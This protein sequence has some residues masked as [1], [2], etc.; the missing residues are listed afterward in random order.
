MTATNNILCHYIEVGGI[1]CFLLSQQRSFVIGK[2]CQYILDWSLFRKKHEIMV[3]S[4]SGKGF[5]I[6]KHWNFS[7]FKNLKN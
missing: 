4:C 7:D 1:L 6:L 3:I 5:D 2:L